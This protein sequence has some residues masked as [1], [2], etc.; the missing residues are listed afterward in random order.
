MAIFDY[1]FD[2]KNELLSAIISLDGKHNLELIKKLKKETVESQF[3]SLVTEVNFGLFLDQF[4]SSLKYGIRHGNQTPDWTLEM[5]NQ[6]LIAEVLRLNPA[7]CDNQNL[8]FSD[9]FANSVREIQIGCILSLDYEAEEIKNEIFDYHW[10]RKEIEKWLLTTPQQNDFITL[11]D[12]ITVELLYFDETLE[13]VC[14]YVRGGR[15]NFD[16]RRLTAENSPLVTKAKKYK[17]LIAKKNIPYLVCIYMDFH[18]WFKKGD[19]YN[20]LYGLSCEHHE[21]PIYYS[22]TIENAL[23]YSQDRIMNDVSGVLLRQNDEHTYFHNFYSANKLN[24]ENKSVLMQWQH[25]YE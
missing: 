14:V 11:L 6:S 13:H 24:Q 12:T 21:D 25:P 7:E 15:I 19:L 8:R 22:H 10:C 23:Y 17:S 20:G 16:Y 2:Q 5:N 18:T 1:F 9:T 4:C 3:L